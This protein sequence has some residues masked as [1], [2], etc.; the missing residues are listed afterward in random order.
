MFREFDAVDVKIQLSFGD[1][2]LGAVGERHQGLLL[3]FGRKLLPRLLLK[4][5]N[6][7][8]PIGLYLLIVA[9]K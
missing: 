4:M 8:I 3:S 5:V 2:L 7:I 1:L 9:R 6:R